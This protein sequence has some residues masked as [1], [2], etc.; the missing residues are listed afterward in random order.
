MIS[1][2]TEETT[3]QTINITHRRLLLKK[4]LKKM[5]KQ[6]RLTKVSKYVFPCF[7][8]SESGVSLE[9]YPNPNQQPSVSIPQLKQ[10]KHN[11]CAHF[12]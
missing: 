8:V 9:D 12:N 6:R 3:K 7:V 2:P 1:I 4:E 11:N 5:K 10:T